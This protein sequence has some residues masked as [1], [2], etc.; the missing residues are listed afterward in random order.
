MTSSQHDILPEFLFRGDLVSLRYGQLNGDM[1]ELVVNQADE[2]ACLAGHGGV[3]G[4]RAQPGAVNGII[5]I[6]GGRKS[7]AVFAEI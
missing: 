4:M 3:D 1:D 7:S 5:G 6:G 2:Q